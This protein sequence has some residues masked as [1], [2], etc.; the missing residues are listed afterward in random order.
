MLII[1]FMQREKL[2][3]AFGKYRYWVEHI[4]SWVSVESIF[5]NG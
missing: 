1:S 4:V 5:S 2:Y 3:K